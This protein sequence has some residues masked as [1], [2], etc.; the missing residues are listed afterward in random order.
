MSSS[1][2]SFKVMASM[3]EVLRE[4]FFSLDFSLQKTCRWKRLKYSV[5]SSSF[6]PGKRPKIKITFRLYKNRTSKSLLLLNYVQSITF[7]SQ[8]KYW[9]EMFDILEIHPRSPG[10]ES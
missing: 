8:V 2:L 7:K 5:L 6:M 1:N 4:F 9:M 3:R 10:E